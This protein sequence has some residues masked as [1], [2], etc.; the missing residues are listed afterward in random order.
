[1]PKLGHTRPMSIS[2][3][4]PAQATH[5]VA[6]GALLAL[7]LAQFLGQVHRIVHPHARP[8]AA[9]APFTAASWLPA[10]QAAQAGHAHAHA[11]AH[12]DRDASG[13]HP[14]ARARSGSGSGSAGSPR[15]DDP[16]RDGTP[17]T[18][19][20][21]LFSGHQYAVDCDA[22]DPPSQVPGL[23][24]AGLPAFTPQGSKA[25]AIPAGLHD[26]APK[27]RAYLARGP[28]GAG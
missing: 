4:R 11:H 13:S 10:L 24:S 17:R 19:W 3:A 23:A 21:R 18:V 7:V 22:Y 28:P 1:M 20:E 26:G 14:E 12:A 8:A 6:W 9:M 16:C 2:R 27:A 25:L 15:S 5:W